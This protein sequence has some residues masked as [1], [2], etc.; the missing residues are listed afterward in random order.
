MSLARKISSEVS[1]TE[2]LEGEL[3]SDVKHEYIDGEVY[4]MAGASMKHNLISS[5][6]SRELGNKLKENNSACNI[7]S[8]DMKV[9][10]NG[11]KTGYFY[12][13]VMIVCDSNDDYYQSSP[14]IIIEVL[15]KSTRKKDK[16]SKKLAYF[17]IP[18]LQEYMI[19]EQDYCEVEVYRKSEHWNSTLYILGDKVPLTSINST[20]SV[21]DIYYHI[22]NEDM[23]HY[24]HKKEE[25]L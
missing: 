17:N 24:L 25:Q 21:E 2:Y 13:D 12:P 7:F 5:N 1:E 14:L 22:D 10:V 20:L 11:I 3:I 15:S 6:V 16:S 8:S 9:K 18:S 19:I 4:A 23:T